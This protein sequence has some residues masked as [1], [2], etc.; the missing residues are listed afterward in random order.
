MRLKSKVTCFQ[1]SKILNNPI[2]L[3][4]RDTICSNHLQEANCIKENKIKC[5]KCNKTFSIRDNNNFRFNQMAKLFLDEF[6]FLSLNEMLLKKQ[7]E[8]GFKCFYQ[9]Q[10]ELVQSKNELAL[11][12]FDHF[13]ELRRQIDLHREELKEKIND[14]QL[15]NKIDD[16]ALDM[17]DKA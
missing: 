1:C 17:I 3:P 15:K 14:I 2:E 11:Q 5:I 10:K 8:D 16:I 7:I 12:C 6:K 9:M 13:Q 4:C